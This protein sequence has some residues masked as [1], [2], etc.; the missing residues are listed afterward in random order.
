M[1]GTQTAKDKSVPLHS[2]AGPSVRAILIRPSIAFLRDQD[3]NQI[4]TRFETRDGTDLPESQH[5]RLPH[6][7]HDAP[8]HA[9]EAYNAAVTVMSLWRAVRPFGAKTCAR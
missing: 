4:G 6:T 3:E 7:Q 9:Y 5:M 1:A 2:C 8:W